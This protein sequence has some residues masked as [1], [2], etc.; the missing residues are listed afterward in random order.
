MVIRSL[1]EKLESFY[2]K[3]EAFDLM[4]IFISE[5]ANNNSY[6]RPGKVILDLD[7]KLS[8]NDFQTFE[9]RFDFLV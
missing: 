6:Y 9:E 7:A 3:Q 2:T 5:L 4:Y 1:I 8:D